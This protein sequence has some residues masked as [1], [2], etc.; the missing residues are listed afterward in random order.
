MD[1]IKYYRTQGVKLMNLIENLSGS[2]M[3]ELNKDLENEFWS[4]ELCK[5]ERGL[6][7]AHSKL[8][9]LHDDLMFEEQ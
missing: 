8:A 9:A 5:D 4:A 3:S 6:K 2:M 7:S 1:K